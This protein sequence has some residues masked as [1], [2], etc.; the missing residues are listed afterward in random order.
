MTSLVFHHRDLGR[1][2]LPIHRGD[3]CETAGIVVE[4]FLTGRDVTLSSSNGVDFL[5]AD[6]DLIEVTR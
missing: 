5:L 6:V 4:N 2:T 3:D 1:L